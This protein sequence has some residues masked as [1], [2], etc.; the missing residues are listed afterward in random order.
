MDKKA[1]QDYSPTSALDLPQ[2]QVA[3]EPRGPRVSGGR[4]PP[5][6]CGVISDN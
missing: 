6:A 4:V 2:R 1:A 5:D 3:C